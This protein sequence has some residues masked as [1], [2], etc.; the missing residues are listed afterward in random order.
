VRHGFSA[1]GFNWIRSGA[2]DMP[3]S[4]EQEDRY[5]DLLLHFLGQR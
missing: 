2:L 3:L 1:V 4:Q 5:H